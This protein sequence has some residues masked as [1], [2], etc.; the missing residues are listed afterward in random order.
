MSYSLNNLL[1]ILSVSQHSSLHYRRGTQ[2]LGHLSSSSRIHRTRDVGLDI[3]L[4]HA[5]KKLTHN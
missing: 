2:R 4:E 3:K 1:N 5:V